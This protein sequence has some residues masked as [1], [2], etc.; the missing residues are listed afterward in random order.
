[1]QLFNF[2]FIWGLIGIILTFIPLS[3]SY[4]IFAVPFMLSGYFLYIVDSV[5]KKSGLRFGSGFL[6]VIGAILVLSSTSSLNPRY[7]QASIYQLLLICSGFGLF[8]GVL[9]IFRGWMDLIKF[10]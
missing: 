4:Y 1:M 2:K 10:I 5:Q 8:T 7:I 3:L 6:L 9:E